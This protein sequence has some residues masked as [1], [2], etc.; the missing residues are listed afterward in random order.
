L[1]ANIHDPP[2]DQ[3]QAARRRCLDVQ[4][5]AAGDPW[6]AYRSVGGR[7]RQEFVAEL[8]AMNRSRQIR[9]ACTVLSRSFAL[10]TGVTTQHRVLGE[11]VMTVRAPHKPL[12][13]RIHVH[14]KWALEHNP[15][16]ELYLRCTRCGNDLYD[17]ERSDRPNIGGNLMGGAG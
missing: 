16:G 7:Y 11:V 3:E 1:S 10:R 8:H 12:L 6:A 13:C 17:V 2:A 5:G 14:H 4:N 9:H 15:D